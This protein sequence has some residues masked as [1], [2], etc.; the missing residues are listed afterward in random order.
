MLQDELALLPLTVR[1]KKRLIEEYGS[2]ENSLE[3]GEAF[4]AL[5]SV[6][7]ITVP[8]R[9]LQDNQKKPLQDQK[10]DSLKLQ[11]LLSASQMVTENYPLPLVGVMQ[12]RFKDFRLTGSQYTE[13]S[14]ASPLYSV[15]CEMVMTDEGSELARIC[16][17]DSTLAVVYHTLVKPGNP[18]RN[19]LTQYSGITPDL[20]EGVTT[21]L[22]EVQEA[23]IALL[24]PD[25]ILVGQSLN[26]DLTAMKMM[27]P[28][29]IDTSVCFNITG[30]RRRKSRFTSQLFYQ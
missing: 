25:A 30:D 13:V 24:P 6:F 8:D 11:L 2:L 12:E 7:P 19:Y 16:V 3:K 9:P 5:R 21:T 22:Q 23:I 10:L 26:C 15:D 1:H 14:P 18:V 27:H 20:L 4:K 17:V 29:V 28:Y